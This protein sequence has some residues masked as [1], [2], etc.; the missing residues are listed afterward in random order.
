MCVDRKRFRASLTTPAG[1]E[2]QNTASSGDGTG[3]GAGHHELGNLG[4]TNS[5]PIITDSGR[6]RCIICAKVRSLFRK[7]KRDSKQSGSDRSKNSVRP[8]LHGLKQ[9]DS[10]RSTNSSCPG[11]DILCNQQ[12]CSGKSNN[13]NRGEKAVKTY[14][15][16]CSTPGP[17]HAKEMPNSTSGLQNNY[18]APEAKGIPSETKSRPLSGT[19][20]SSEQSVH[21]QLSTKM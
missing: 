21:E 8:N 3:A 6:P 15:N 18:V 11:P 9:S 19:S 2:A 16:G 7:N 5:R 14:T 10:D 1:V 17:G 20:A 13:N 4:H 12:I